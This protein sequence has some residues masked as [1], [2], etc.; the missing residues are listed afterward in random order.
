MSLTRGTPSTM[1]PLRG[2]QAFRN[3]PGWERPGSFISINWPMSGEPLSSITLALSTES[4]FGHPTMAAAA[5]RNSTLACL[6]TS[7]GSKLARS[8]IHFAGTRVPCQ[9]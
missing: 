6:M 3:R 8:S 1:I 9:E 5:A 2:Q 4:I 7:F